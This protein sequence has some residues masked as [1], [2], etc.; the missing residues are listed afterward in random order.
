MKFRLKQ[1]YGYSKVKDLP[2]IAVPILRWKDEEAEFARLRDPIRLT[3]HS[4]Q[5]LSRFIYNLCYKLSLAYKEWGARDSEIGVNQVLGKE[6]KFQIY[7][8][9]K[10]QGQEKRNNP[11]SLREVPELRFYLSF[12]SPEDSLQKSPETM[13]FKTTPRP[14][15]TSFSRI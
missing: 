1:T 12:L 7:W 6:S 9:P 11:R 8:G 2:E 5:K 4:N 3:F 10:K 13:V 15:T 14:N